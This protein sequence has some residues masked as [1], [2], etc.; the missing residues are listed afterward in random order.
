MAPTCL[1]S[2]SAQR[3]RAVK[4]KILVMGPSGSGKTLGGLRTVAGSTAARRCC[5]TCATAASA[6]NCDWLQT[7]KPVAW[8]TPETCAAIDDAIPLL[9][10]AKQVNARQRWAARRDKGVTEEEAQQMLAALGP[11]PAPDA[12]HVASDA[13]RAALEAAVVRLSALNPDL[14]EDAR[15]A[16]EAAIRVGQAGGFSRSLSLTQS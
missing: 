15:A 7:A 3:A 2:S 10:E 6:L 4:L 12:A 16:P 5:G 9:R 8:P 13:D 14:A 11:A 1:S